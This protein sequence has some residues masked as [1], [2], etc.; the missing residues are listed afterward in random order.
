[1]LIDHA[2]TASEKELVADLCVVG[3]GAAGI[4]LA[5]EFA[6]SKLQV[7][8]LESG[9]WESEAD[10]QA[11]YLTEQTGKPIQ[12]AHTGRFRILGGSTTQW[13]G[14]SLPMEPLDFERREWVERSGWPISYRDLSSYYDRANR[15]LGVDTLDYRDETAAALRLER[16]QF[17]QK[18]VEYHF[19]KWAP[20]PD[21]RKKYSAQLV[22]S[23]NVKVILHANLTEIY[24]DGER[25][26]SAR[27]RSLT[28]RE[29]SI[30][31]AEFVL[32][33]GGIEVPRILLASCRQVSA[34]L[35]N[36]HDQVGRCLQEHPAAR[37]G[38]VEAADLD[39][40]Q[41]LFNGRRAQGRRF[42]ARLSLSRE[43]QEAERLLNASAGFLFSL[44][45]DHGFG[46][47]RAAVKGQRAE[48][49]KLAPQKVLIESVRCL[50]QLIKS[51]WLLGIRGRVFTPGATCE[52]AASFEQEPD[53]TSRVSL[54][55]KR[56][57]LGMP[58]ARIH[59]QLT[60]KTFDTAVRFAEVI[61]HALQQ[62][63]VGRL[64]VSSWIYDGGG[65]YGKHFHDQNHHMGTTRMSASPREGVVDANLKVHS[66]QNLFIASSATFPTGGHSNP[67]LT[68]LALTIRL[69]DHLKL[70]KKLN[71]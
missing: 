40:L 21:L 13:G 44:P 50:P 22:Q 65:D 68:M 52:L 54:S 24:V 33:T 69:A 12:S 5:M 17:P 61:D 62:L 16:P 10:T 26:T 29:G 53:P 35:G 56:D 23:R 9:G 60:R 66:M 55:E 18:L 57:A 15:F 63:R 47:V 30:V 8:I 39:K 28:G 27:Y 59:W 31:A 38:V 43:I 20:Q 2:D 6:N 14:Q 48:S 3:A 64:R 11:L 45:A 19:S 37:L 41:M 49:A 42:S 71:A 51:S 7:V 67:T 4:A 36:E 25:V 46:L 70:K 34:G 32:A 1:M 58:L